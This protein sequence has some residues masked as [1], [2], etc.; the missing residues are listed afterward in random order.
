MGPSIA[1]MVSTSV[2]VSPF[3]STRDFLPRNRTPTVCGNGHGLRSLFQ[4]GGGI[5]AVNAL[6]FIASG[7]SIQ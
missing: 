6:P 5:H 4:T 1:A 2:F 7:V 3:L